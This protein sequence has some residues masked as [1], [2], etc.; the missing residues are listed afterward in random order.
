MFEPGLVAAASPFLSPPIFSLLLAGLAVYLRGPGPDAWRRQRDRRRHPA[1]TARLMAAAGTVVA[2]A[3]IVA[4]IAVTTEPRPPIPRGVA[5]T[6]E[7]PD[8]RVQ[9]ATFVLYDPVPG[10][11]ES[12]TPVTVSGASF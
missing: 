7:D 8:R 12:L 6:V 5:V 9:R 10:G 4:G 2:G 3:A 1:R 11:A